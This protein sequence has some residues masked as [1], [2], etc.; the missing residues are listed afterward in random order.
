M[1]YRVCFLWA[2]APPLFFVLQLQL[3][4]LFLPAYVCPFVRAALAAP[5]GIVVVVVVVAVVI[6]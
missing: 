3:L 5:A 1:E 6:L 4:R 2:N